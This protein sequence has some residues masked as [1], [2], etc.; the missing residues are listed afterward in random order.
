M[1]TRRITPGSPLEPGEADGLDGA[2]LTRDL[3]VDGDRWR[4]GRRLTRSE[5]RRLVEHGPDDGDRRPI[6]LL[7]P[8]ADDL[9]EDQAA[10]RLANA[11]A[12]SGVT[13][14][15][16]AE[17]RVDL[18][19]SHDGVLR[20][21]VGALER[22][23]RLD[24]VEV[25]TRL[26]GQVIQAG[27]VVASV[28]VAPHVLPAAVITAAERQ[29]GERGVVRV[30][31]YQRVVV[32]VVVKEALRAAAR[33]RF[34]TTMRLRVEGLGSVVGPIHYVADDVDAVRAALASVVRGPEPARL[35]LMAGSASTDPLDATF[36]A[37]DA[38][39]GRVIR[40]GVPAHPGS[41]LWMARIGRATVLG[42]PTCGAYSRATAADL[43]IPWLLAGAPPTRA[44][45]A[46][47]GHGGVLTRDQ[48]FR[49]PAYAQD[50]E[51]PE[52]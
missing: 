28:K 14:H 36:L 40:Q 44:T 50:L 31:G 38:L 30:D 46:R 32:G 2:V 37:I 29:A 6:T 24:Q 42:L 41:M 10:R 51:A 8:G 20:V 34:E 19:A 27:D 49:F 15:G 22:V 48:R 16:P 52:G 33:E 9:H 23:D 5:I 21:R 11:V 4:K 25:F 3:V 12:G 17:S 47:L 39:G 7:L 45:I 13:L 1:D 26:D 35:V 43:L 18:L